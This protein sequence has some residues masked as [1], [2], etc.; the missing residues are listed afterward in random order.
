MT[1]F[2]VVVLAFFSTWVARQSIGL[3][4]LSKASGASGHN[5]VDVRLMAGVPQNGIGG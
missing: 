3:T 5:F 1:V 2:D 4:K